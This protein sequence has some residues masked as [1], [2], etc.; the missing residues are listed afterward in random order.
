MATVGELA[1]EVGG[2]R[3]R[4]RAPGGLRSGHVEHSCVEV[5]VGPSEGERLADPQA[6]ERAAGDDGPELVAELA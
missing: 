2:Q 6:G 1:D 4:L 3:H 5:D